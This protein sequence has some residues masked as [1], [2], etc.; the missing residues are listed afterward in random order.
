LRTSKEYEPC[1]FSVWLVTCPKLFFPLG[2]DLPA[3]SKEDLEE[4]CLWETD[5]SKSSNLLKWY[6]K[7]DDKV[8]QVKLNVG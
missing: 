8:M 7:F 1:L 6:P 2:Q 4:V 5:L 3:S